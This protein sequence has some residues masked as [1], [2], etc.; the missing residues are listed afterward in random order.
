MNFQKH[1]SDLIALPSVSSVN[2]GWDQSNSN[3]IEM[4]EHSYRKLGFNTEIMPVP[5]TTDKF[6]LIASTGTGADGLV[7]SGHTDTVPFDDNKWNSDPF[8]L[9]EKDGRFYGLGVSDMK[10]FFSLI[11]IALQ[12]FDIHSFKHPLVILATADEETTMCGAE[13]L[14]NSGKKL[15]RHAII[16]EPTNGRPVR[17]HKGI[18]MESIRLTGL[19]GHSSNPNLGNNA[20]EGMYLVMAEIIQWRKELANNHRNPLF[21]VE[22]PTVNLGHIHGG[23]NPNRICS[24]CEL[25]IDIRP[26][27]GMALDDLKQELHQRLHRIIEPT[28]LALETHALFDGI[29]AMETPAEAAIVKAVEELTGFSAEAVAFGTEAPYLNNMGMETIIFGPGSID[30]AHQPDEYLTIKDIQ[31]YIQQLQQL[32]RIF[33]L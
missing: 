19:S 11:Q 2:P 23:D 30:Q 24:S 14:M 18:A 16:G 4:L 7:L 20:M 21:E 8:Q 5:G 15:G 28:G 29:P 1:L 22:Y 26:L 10:S 9:T 6:N 17:M 31:P 33:C 27:P 32:I 12:D 25:Q 13:S 3:M